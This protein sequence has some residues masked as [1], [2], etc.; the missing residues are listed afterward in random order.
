MENFGSAVFSRNTVS[1]FQ[2]VGEKGVSSRQYFWILLLSKDFV[3][4][5]FHAC[6]LGCLLEIGMTRIESDD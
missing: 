1:L 6:S 5:S 2:S 3:Q 4:G